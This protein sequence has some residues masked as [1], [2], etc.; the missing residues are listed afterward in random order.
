MRYSEITNPVKPRKAVNNNG[1]TV[2]KVSNWE[3]LKRFLILGT[4]GGT[5]YVNQ[6]KLTLDNNKT[7]QGLLNED[8]VKVVKIVSEI[9]LAGRA[10]KQDPAIFVLA[11]AASHP[12][13]EVRQAAFAALPEVCRTA[14]HLMQFVSEATQMRGWG[15]ALKQAVGKWYTGKSVDEAAYQ[16]IKYKNRFGWS[17][18]DLLRQS[19][20]Y[21]PDYSALFKWALKGTLENVPNQVIAS[22]QVKELWDKDGAAALPGISNLIKQHNLPREIVPTEALNHVEVW[23]ALSEKM[24]I[25]ATIRNLATMTRIGY[26]APMSDSSRQLVEKL[27]NQELLRKGRVHPFSLL[28]ALNSYSTGVSKGDKT[29]TPV[30]EIVEAL[31]RAFYLSF[32]SVT[33]ANKRTY[34][35]LD[36]S[37]SMTWNMLPGTNLSAAQASM[38][39]S[40]VSLN[41]EPF[42]AM[43][44]FS[45]TLVP[46]SI[47]KHTSIKEGLEAIKRVNFGG[48][49]CAQPMIHARENNI[50]VDT[51]I[52]YT[53]NETRQSTTSPAL[54]L[55]QYKQRMGI[56][57]KLVVVGMVSNG[58][59][60]A[61]PLNPRMLDIV[62]F[63]ANGPQAISE[64]SS[65]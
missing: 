29:H 4:E 32:D 61:D 18:V 3:T 7:I 39:M 35:G 15:R 44:G 14:T 50:P 31:E 9:S 57:A 25:T 26:L 2:F 30:Q 49:D 11:L 55:E 59:S 16:M 56:D 65:M 43:Y 53:D 33:P 47:F 36:V 20:P 6:Q 27:T 13:L 41:T 28:L 64:F 5:Y 45:S 8:G 40:L 1:G 12:N 60:I 54:A 58:F 46:L 23:E 17:H 24:P 52:I 62:G 19:H 21:H 38:A 22:N 48:T 10:I 42:T 63:D 37:G 34:I 51:F